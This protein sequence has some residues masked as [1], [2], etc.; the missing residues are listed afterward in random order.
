MPGTT[1]TSAALGS[2]MLFVD[3]SPHCVCELL[4]LLLLLLLPVFSLQ[5]RK[6]SLLLSSSDAPLGIE[7]NWLLYLLRNK[8]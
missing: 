6:A 5:I 8:R 7:E 2:M 1:T 4:L 3:T